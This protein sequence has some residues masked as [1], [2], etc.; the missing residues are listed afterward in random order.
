[1]GYW[2]KSKIWFCAS[3]IY[4]DTRDFHVHVSIELVSVAVET[5]RVPTVEHWMSLGTI[6]LCQN[7]RETVALAHT[8][9][10]FMSL[11]KASKN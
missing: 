6:Y 1:M 2:N 7:S 3:V 9:P 5:P 8:C 10:F 11:E 4:N